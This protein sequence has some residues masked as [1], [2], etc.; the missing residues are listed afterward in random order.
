MLLQKY[1]DVRKMIGEAEVRRRQLEVAEEAFESEDL[2]V[3]D[4]EEPEKEESEADS[5]EDDIFS[6]NGEE[7]DERKEQDITRAGSSQLGVLKRLVDELGGAGTS[8]EEKQGTPS[9]RKRREYSFL[10]AISCSFF[11]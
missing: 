5:E 10:A 8:T 1:Y 3:E 6:Q 7:D 11:S 2:E 4:E 9:C